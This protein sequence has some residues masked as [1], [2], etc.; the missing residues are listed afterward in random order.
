MRGPRQDGGPDAARP[1]VRFCKKETAGVMATEKSAGRLV[2]ECKA[3]I[4]RHTNAAQNA[5][6][7]G[8][9]ANARTLLAKKQEYEET[10]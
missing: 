4:A 1:T 3:N 7:A 6:R 10:W 9:E 5:L 8:N 2:D